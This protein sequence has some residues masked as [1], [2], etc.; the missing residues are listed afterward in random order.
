MSPYVS[1]DAP[2][3]WG[4]AKNLTEAVSLESSFNER[5][6]ETNICDQKFP[7]MPNFSKPGR[8]ISEQKC[9]EYIWDIKRREH[10]KKQ[11]DN[12]CFYTIAAVGGRDALP[13][14]FPHMAAVGWQAAQGTW[15]FKCGSSLISPNFVLTAAHCSSTAV[16][17]GS[18]A[19]PVP[20]IVRLGDR[21]ILEKYFVSCLSTYSVI[22][23]VVA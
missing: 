8:R 14:E 21:D 16:T 4:V 2:W 5:A 15:I 10:D 7:E 22:G 13:G 6:K 23:H 11:L 9:Y 17:D 20:K 18:V 1:Q 12:G 19:D 3:F